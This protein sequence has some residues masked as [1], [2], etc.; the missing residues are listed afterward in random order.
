[1]QYATYFKINNS[2]EDPKQV[3][4]LTKGKFP[5]IKTFY[6]GELRTAEYYNEVEYFDFQTQETTYVSEVAVR[7]TYTWTRKPSGIMY[8][9][10]SVLVEY[11]R[12][13][14]EGDPLISSRNID[15]D[16]EE[17]FE[18]AIK[19]LLRNLYRLGGYI[20]DA[21]QT[22]AFLGL[23]GLAL[24]QKT[25]YEHAISLPLIQFVNEAGDGE[26]PDSQT[27]QIMSAP[28]PNGKS[29]RQYSLEQL[30]VDQTIDYTDAIAYI[31]A[32]PHPG[33]NV[34]DIINS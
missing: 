20:D 30:F 22:P 31:Q 2:P 33:I 32:N 11:I 9:D 8:N 15:F 29:V 4:Y 26:A 14:G 6:K 12:Y 3:D 13:D 16:Y 28:L 23:F 1:M 19:R 25:A 17:Q 21:L 24:E 27:N 5:V 18:Y 34:N 7:E 10:L